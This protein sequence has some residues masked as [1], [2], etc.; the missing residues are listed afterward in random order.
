MKRNSGWSGFGTLILFVAGI[1]FF[2]LSVT[3]LGVLPGLKLER[4]IREH[5][6]VT[7][8]PYTPA[9][10]HG[11]QIYAV[12]GCAYCHSEQ[13]RHTAG[14][15]RRWGP[16]TAPWETKYNSPQ[17][18]GTRRIGPDLAR[19]TGVRTDDWQLVHLFDPRHVVPGSVMPGYTWLFHGDASRP[20]LDAR[21]LVAYLDTLGRPRRE[22]AKAPSA[23]AA[24]RRGMNA[25][26]ARPVVASPGQSMQAPTQMGN[27]DH[28][29]TLFAENCSGCHGRRGDGDSVAARTLRPA[30]SNLTATRYS[31]GALAAI[32]HNGVAGSSMP[33]WRD[34]NGQRQADLIAFVQQLHRP[35]TP[36]QPDVVS[37]AKGATL[38][39][40]DCAACHG[41]NGNG[42]GA[43]SIV[44]KPRPFNFQHLQPN[45]SEVDRVL[46]VG[47]AGAGM[48][49]FPGLDAGD[50][51][52]LAHYVR[53]LYQSEAAGA[54]PVK[55]D[56][57]S[58]PVA[59]S[60][61]P[62]LP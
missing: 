15:E 51:Q 38:Y 31:A 7:E 43:A 23:D 54:T 11:R 10:A 57:R 18:W 16:P 35:E 37:V 59:S 46:R 24:M 14:D 1:G 26:A 3:A 44:L 8:T 9:E 60:T 33:A 61:A 4:S 29:K 47:V 25:N 20:T 50:R 12:E 22:A 49:A 56:V 2:V 13:V 62:V 32:L 34:L 28:G 36:I 45:V 6:P 48:P 21:D 42:D 27:I 5:A 39:A 19:E 55:H 30:P 53:S 58:T 40:V 41:V 17:L 52:A